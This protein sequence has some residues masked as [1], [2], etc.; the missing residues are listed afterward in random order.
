MDRKEVFD[1][2]DKHME[3]HEQRM[4]RLAIENCLGLRKKESIRE[5]A[6]SSASALAALEMLK[7][8]LNGEKEW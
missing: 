8:E 3:Y 6:D 2:I 5:D 7:M 4:F 1:V